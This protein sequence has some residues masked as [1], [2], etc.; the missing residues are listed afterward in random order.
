MSRLR[1]IAAH[2]AE[3]RSYAA[4]QE[5]AEAE[6]RHRLAEEHYA[7]LCRWNRELLPAIERAAERVTAA[8]GGRTDGDYLDFHSSKQSQIIRN[9]IDFGEQ[10][11]ISLRLVRQYK[12]GEIIKFAI[13]TSG[14]PDSAVLV[15][16][17]NGRKVVRLVVDERV[18]PDSINYWL[19]R[20]VHESVCS[21]ER[22][23]S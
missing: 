1:E 22:A 2:A 13:E 16:T 17:R 19:E 20:I 23:M 7:A 6:R 18:G 10:M 15:I 11:S 9:Q 5:A 3:A 14:G 12:F 4:E 8:L 21:N